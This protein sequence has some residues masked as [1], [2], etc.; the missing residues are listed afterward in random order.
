MNVQIEKKPLSIDLQMDVLAIGTEESE[1]LTAQ[2]PLHKAYAALFT[3]ESLERWRKTKAI[4]KVHTFANTGVKSL[5]FTMPSSKQ[6]TRLALKKAF[7][8][9]IKLWVTEERSSVGIALDTYATTS[10]S[11]VEV[12]DIF[13]EAL[14]LAS[15]KLPSYK[16]SSSVYKGIENVMIITDAPKED[17]QKAIQKGKAYGAGTCFAR[18]LVNLPANELT[19][20]ALAEQALTLADTY[21]FEATILEKADMERLGMGALLAVN[22]GSVEPPKMIVLSYKGDPSSDDTVAL[23]GK[24]ITFDTGGYS[25][26]TKDG[27]VGMKADMGGAGAVLGAMQVIGELQ[28]KK[29]VLCVIPSTDNMIS[30]SAFKPDDVVRAMNGMTIEIKNTDAEGRLALADAVA[31][32]VS[33][34]ATE[35]IDVAT[36]TGGVTV[37]LGDTT[38]G[39]MTNNEELYKEV[40]QA[41][42]TCDEP[43]WLLPSFDTYKERVR[44]SDIADLNNSPGRLAHPIMGGLFVGEF[45]SGKPWV[46][47]DIAGT[48]TTSSAHALGP[49]GATGVMVRT[50]ANFI[51]N[52]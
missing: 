15:Y 28:P 31:Y 45:T 32:S 20:T 3:E 4:E 6:Q 40:E 51:C 14:E 39:A 11:I 34:G 2:S 35:I 33:K 17:V 36:L 21:S 16:A 44:S 25:I 38:T 26:K 18:Q 47:L 24:G 42:K 50:L 12:A 29:N 46:H 13:A 7:G 27:L 41:A 1:R 37:A 48:A 22:Q 49:K 43:I 52:A 10:R 30:A 19:A 8:K 5:Y 23:I 9:L